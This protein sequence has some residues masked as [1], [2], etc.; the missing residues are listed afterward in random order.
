MYSSVAVHVRPRI[1]SDRA[2]QD[3]R[4]FDTLQPI[5]MNRSMGN[6]SQRILIT[7][8]KFDWRSWRTN[9]IEPRESARLLR[10]KCAEHWESGKIRGIW[11]GKGEAEGE[12]EGE[13][14]W[15]RYAELI[16]SSPA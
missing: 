9:T 7:P 16:F 12:L 3:I 10:G 14:N 5:Y 2:Y 11:E 4:M 15:V 1:P 13:R 6:I 8:L